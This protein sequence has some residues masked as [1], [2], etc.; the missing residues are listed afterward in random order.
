[1]ILHWEIEQVSGPNNKTT[2]TGTTQ[3]DQ[4]KD[5]VGDGRASV[6]VLVGTQFN[7]GEAKTHVVVR[8]SCNQDEKTIQTAG[9]LAFWKAK[10]LCESALNTLVPPLP[11]YQPPGPAP[12]SPTAPSYTPGSVGPPHPGTPR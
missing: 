7:F 3:L 6:E 11:P 10:E 5:L 2:T 1:V 4:F 9:Q 8:L 12:Y